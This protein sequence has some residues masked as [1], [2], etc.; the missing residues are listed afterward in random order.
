MCLSL[1]RVLLTGGILAVAEIA[2]SQDNPTG[3]QP[4]PQRQAAPQSM[5]PEQRGTNLRVFLGLGAEPD[6][7]AASRGEPKFQQNCAFC[8]GPRARGATV[9]A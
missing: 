8:H 9:P 6:K 4:A 1:F 3:D 5:T 2:A 7:A